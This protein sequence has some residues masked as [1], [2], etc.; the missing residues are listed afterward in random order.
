MAA[1]KKK[2]RA[3]RGPA[4]NRFVLNCVKSKDTVDDWSFGDAVC[5][6]FLADKDAAPTEVDLR[7]DWWTVQNQKTSGA[8]VG[9]ATADGV[10]RWHYVREKMIEKDELVSPRFIWMANKETDDFTRYPT[11]FLDS[12]GTSTKLALKVAKKYGCV[13]EKMLPMEGR[14]SRMSPKSLAEK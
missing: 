2:A 7:R 5:A 3:G 10:L 6:E 13:P 11:T 9:F 1:A 8:C 12:A 4:A 14:L